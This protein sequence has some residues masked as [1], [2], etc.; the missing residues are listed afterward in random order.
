M[1]RVLLIDGDVLA[2]RAACAV[3]IA[4]E[5][6]PGYWTWHCEEDEVKRAITEEIARYMKALEADEYK[7]C[8][9]DTDNFRKRIL[10][11]YKGKRAS[12]RKPLVLKPIRE[13]LLARGAVMR[14]GLEGDDVMGI[15][16]TWSG[17]KGEKIIV[18]IDKDMKTIPGLYCRD[19]EA[20]VVE[21][22]EGAANY[23]HMFQTLT[24]D[25]TDGYGGCPGIGP[26]KATSIIQG[27]FPEG[28]RGEFINTSAG[29]RAVWEAI[30]ASYKDK[31]L[32]EAEAVTQ[33][34][35]ARILRASDFNFK[36]KQPVLWSPGKGR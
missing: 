27:C 15:L 10:S 30:V 22:S 36:T 25:V 7:V 31:K 35:V 11:T 17:L 1:S 21:V 6:E 16:S 34:R 23:W 26:V 8:L 18:S 9:T 33:A 14:P 24:G 32:G 28:S 12:V 19:L 20:G 5:W 4:T 2:Y 29:L 13:W 3:E